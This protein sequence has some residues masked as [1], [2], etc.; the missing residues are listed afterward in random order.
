MSGASDAQSPPTWAQRQ[1]E[2]FGTYVG[3]FLD[4]VQTPEER[5]RA[6]ELAA[7]DRELGPPPDAVDAPADDPEH[8]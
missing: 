8:R 2:D 7:M 6:E 3:R 1:G 5:A 4:E